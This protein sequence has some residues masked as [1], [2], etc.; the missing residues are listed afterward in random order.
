MSVTVAKSAGFCF[1]VS[2]AVEMVEK[3]AQGGTQ[4]CT[5]G[6]IIHN[7]HAVQHF[8]NMGI[9]DFSA[10]TAEPV[11]DQPVTLTISLYNEEPAEFSVDSVVLYADG[12]PVCTMEEPR[13]VST[14]ETLDLSISYTHP[15]SGEAE[16]RAVV[17]GHVRDEIR[18]CEKTLTLRFRSGIT[19]TGILVD[20]SNTNTGLDQLER[21]CALAEEM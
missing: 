17:R 5:L 7:R 21:F 15:V 4:V 10:D 13:T 8:E 19:A 14:G 20:G 12:E 18:S 6:P 3:C 9:R 16:L 1:G 2:R 11:Q